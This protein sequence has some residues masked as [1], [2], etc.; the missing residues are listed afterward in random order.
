MRRLSSARGLGVLLSLALVAAAPGAA[1]AVDSGTISRFL[2]LSD[3]FHAQLPRSGV[4]GLSDSQRRARAECILTGFEQAH[5]SGGVKALMELMGVLSKSPEF[6]DPTVVAFNNR[7]GAT[8]D[9]MVRQCTQSAR[10][11]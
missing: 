10:S 7:Y 2:R 6:D 9:P 8:Y 11:S 1:A 3:Q 5:G 4:E